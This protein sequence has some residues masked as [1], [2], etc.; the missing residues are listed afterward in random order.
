MRGY[1]V[2]RSCVARRILQASL[3][4]LVFMAWNSIQI[5]A[6]LPSGESGSSAQ[7]G[8]PGDADYKLWRGNNEFAVWGAGSFDA[9]TLIGNT[10][11]RDVGPQVWE[12][13]RYN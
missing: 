9:P 5:R 7:S 11:D 13:C 4:F 10:A 3:F 6:Q 8:D 12:G 2:G 1:Q